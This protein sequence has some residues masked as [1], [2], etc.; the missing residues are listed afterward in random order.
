MP[1]KFSIIAE[2]VKLFL[3]PLFGRKKKMKKKKKILF[4]K[5]N[6]LIYNFTIQPVI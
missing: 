5:R 4:K 3:F 2:C 1:F 6:W